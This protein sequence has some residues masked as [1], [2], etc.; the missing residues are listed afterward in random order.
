MLTQMLALDNATISLNVNPREAAELLALAHQDEAWIQSLFPTLSDPP[1]LRRH[2]RA[3][4]RQAWHEGQTF[5]GIRQGQTLVAVG[6]TALPT[7]STRKLSPW[8]RIAR[9][10]NLLPTLR[11]VGSV[12]ASYLSWY[13][14]FAHET[15]PTA[16]HARLEALGVHPGRR[17]Q[18]LA[19]QLLKAIHLITDADTTS[20][21][22]LLHTDNPAA[23]AL[24][25]QSG[26]RIIRTTTLD[27]MTLHALF[28]PAPGSNCKSAPGRQLGHG[29]ASHQ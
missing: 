14:K 21:G 8:D 19:R 18:G 22:V 16:P 12:E 13:L 20:T 28:R 9:L 17:R 4:C 26:Y 15:R 23:L 2:F 5:A 7:S 3:I 25:R 1:V 10:S 11:Y 27:D 29:P 24:Y 6:L